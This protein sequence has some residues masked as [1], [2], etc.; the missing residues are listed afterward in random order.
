MHAI[1]IYAHPWD[2]SFNHHVLEQTIDLL[3]KQGKTVDIIDLNKDG[4]NPVL[5][6][7]DLKLFGQGKYHD[8]LAEAYINRLKA[9]DEVVLVFPIWWYGEPAILK[10]FYDKVFL[11]GQA[12]GE[13][14]HK[15]KGMLDIH[16]AT[17]ITTANISKEIFQAIGDP[18]NNVLAHGVFETVGI[19]HVTWIHCQTVHM[20]ASRASFLEEIKTHFKA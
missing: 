18:I 14:D 15:L 12:Y 8:P 16:K 4:F 2:G 20:P 11:K 17:I 3:K 1:I 13:V 5:T 9:A 6:Q 10:G 19:D 7:N